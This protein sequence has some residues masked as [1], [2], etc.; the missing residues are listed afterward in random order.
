MRSLGHLS[1]SGW[2]GHRDVDRF[3]QREPGGER[4]ALRRRVAGAQLTSVLP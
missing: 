4:Q 3:D 1:I 2:P